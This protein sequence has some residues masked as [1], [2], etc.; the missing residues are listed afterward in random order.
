MFTYVKIYQCMFDIDTLLIV[1]YR[2][3]KLL[4]KKHNCNKIAI[5]QIY[6][7]MGRLLMG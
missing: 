4:Q 1:T 3:K 6:V 2:L 5:V 7:A